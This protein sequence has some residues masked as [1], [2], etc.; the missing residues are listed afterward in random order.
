MTVSKIKQDTDARMQKCLA[1]FQAELSKIRTGRASPAL[2]EHIKIDSYGSEMPLNQVASINAQDSRTLAISPWDKGLISV[3]E[4][5]IMNANLGFNPT[6]TGDV[7]RIPMPPMT[8]ERRKDMTRV[9]RNEAEGARVAIRNVRREAN[10]H[11]KDLLKDK[12]VTEDE[13]H[14]GQDNIQKLTDK[15]VGEVDKQ[16]TAKETD[17]MS[18]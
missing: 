7:I 6:T 13:E 18:V 11:I 15:F 17:I 4:K 2:V 3:I 8:E 16:A 12:L 14:R 5:A 9:I 1:A 10:Q